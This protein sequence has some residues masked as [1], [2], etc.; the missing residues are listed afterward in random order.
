MQYFGDLGFLQMKFRSSRS[1]VKR[2]ETPVRDASLSLPLWPR[3]LLRFSELLQ[4]IHFDVLSG[5]SGPP[6]P[7]GWEISRFSSRLGIIGICIMRRENSQ[8]KAPGA[9]CVS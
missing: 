6:D 5:G 2:Q 7:T 1:S 4:S 9:G 8:K 3:R